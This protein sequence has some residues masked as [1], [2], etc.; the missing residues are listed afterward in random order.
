MKSV[1]RFEA[2]MLRLLRALLGHAPAEQALRIIM[3]NRERPRCLS[4]NAVELAQDTLSKGVVLWFAESGWRRETFL[5]NDSAVT[6]RLWERTPAA[7][8]ELDFSRASL[9]WL[10]WLTASHPG[11]STWEPPVETLTTGDEIL[12]AI[13]FDRLADFPAARTLTDQPIFQSRALPQLLWPE[14]FGRNFAGAVDFFSWF[15]PDRVWVLEALQNSLVQRWF[16]MEHAK[17]SMV[18][19]EEL[20]QHGQRQSAVLERF[21]GA[22]EQTHRW[23]L[24]RF[25]LV[26]AIRL[27]HRVLPRD[28]WFPNINLSGLRFADRSA[29]YDAGLLLLRKVSRLE[30][31]EQA[32]RGVGYLDDHYAASQLWKSDW[33]RLNGP[34][35]AR[36]AGE[37]LDRHV[38]FRV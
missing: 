11:T 9:D 7:D 38:A 15:E 26:A 1:S 29:V 37:I 21:L 10:I 8:R 36:T 12:L 5:R 28:P 3:R 13:T 31:W 18:E 27:L 6:G 35:V 2:E 17:C 25:L 30:S 19:W 34:A 16:D 23:D 32:A 22:V 20:R 14:H 33:E 24:A 4:R